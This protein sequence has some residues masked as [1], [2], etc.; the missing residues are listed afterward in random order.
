MMF[1]VEIRGSKGAFVSF[2]YLTHCIYFLKGLSAHTHVE[3]PY[4]SKFLLIAAYLAS[5]NPART[6]KRFFLKVRE[7]C[8]FYMGQYRGDRRQGGEGEK[9]WISSEGVFKPAFGWIRLWF[10]F[11]LGMIRL[12]RAEYL[13]QL[14]TWTSAMN[15]VAFLIFGI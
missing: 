3:L 12:G 8:L 5:Y 15:Y 11:P 10:V 14:L 13:N 4:Y 7:L 6:D 2:V 9:I 1:W